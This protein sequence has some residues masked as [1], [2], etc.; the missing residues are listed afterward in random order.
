[1]VYTV[2]MAIAIG[3]TGQAEQEEDAR[4]REIIGL[5]RKT[6]DRYVM[7]YR[8][9]AAD[10]PEMAFRVVE[11]PV[12]LWNQPVRFN[13]IG[14]VY[15]WV[16]QDGRP[17]AIGTLYCWNNWKEFWAITHEFHSLATKPIKTVWRGETI[18]A[19]TEPGLKWKVLP[20]AAQPGDSR[21]MQL[22]QIRQ[23]SRKFRA[24]TV[25]KK[26]DR[27]ELR[28]LPKPLHDYAI[29]KGQATMAGAVFAMCQG[30]DPELLLAIESQSTDQGT[31][32]H[33]ACGAFTDYELHVDFRG[34]EIWSV[35]PT[36]TGG[37]SSKPYWRNRITS[38]ASLPEE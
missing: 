16:Q 11:K 19:P 24:H 1:M 6:F 27:W 12:F 30:M 2:L 23:L 7:E 25:D 33:C 3:A 21:R 10:E 14:S 22:Q 28:L 4:Q 31:R 32:W 35:S 15:M 26:G 18:W 37:D 8:I 29:E 9:T 5:W 17:G 13:Q 38:R 20:G 36:E 34:T